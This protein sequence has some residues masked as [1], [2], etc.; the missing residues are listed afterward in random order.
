M[1]R[2]WLSVCM[3]ACDFEHEIQFTFKNAFLANPELPHTGTKSAAT[4]HVQSRLRMKAV[5]NQVHS[6]RRAPMLPKA[7]PNMTATPTNQAAST[8]KTAPPRS[9]HEDIAH[10]IYTE[11]Q[12]KERIQEL[13]RWEK[14]SFFTT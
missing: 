10:V 5:N 13:G 7:V 3:E 2:A 1:H 12:L 11:A 6:A 9:Y 4:Q 14:R 8:K